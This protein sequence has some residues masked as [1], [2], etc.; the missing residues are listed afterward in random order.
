MHEDALA[1]AAVPTPAVVLG[2]LMRPF[3]VGHVVCLIREG[4]LSDCEARTLTSRGL[5]TAA[6]ICSQSWEEY[7][8][9][10]GDWT[11]SLKLWLW[12]KRVAIAERIHSRIPGAAPY[13]LEQS[14][15]LYRY[16]EAGSIGFPFSD[17]PRADSDTKVRMFGSP[18]LI[19][20]HNWLTV[21]LGMSYSEAWDHPYG[22]AKMRW[23]AHWEQ[24]GALSIKN[25]A[26]ESFDRY[27]AEQ[28]AAGKKALEKDNQCHP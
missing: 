7:R 2:L 4:I 22:L 12:R 24:E 14:D 5:A 26:D 1:I 27:I 20:L 18:F 16:I 15:L 3:S 23:S 10:Q 17:S 11:L 19:R 21:E 28:E 25:E 9:S 13:F 8:E 6:L